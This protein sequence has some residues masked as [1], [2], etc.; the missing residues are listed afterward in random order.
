MMFQVLGPV[1][2]IET[3]ATGREIRELKRLRDRYGAGRW[4]KRKG[5]ALVRLDDGAI[6][7]AEVH[8]YEAR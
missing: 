3:I 8:R 1:R 5:L 2:Q 7:E 6:R 4:R